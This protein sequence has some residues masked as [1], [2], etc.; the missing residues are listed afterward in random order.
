MRPS[1]GH[2]D[3]RKAESQQRRRPKSHKLSYKNRW[4]ISRDIVAHLR[5]A[6]VVCNII[7]P[8]RI[9]LAQYG[10]MS[11]GERAALMLLG[12]GVS[13]DDPKLEEVPEVIAAMREIKRVH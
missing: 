7:V 12:S 5:R 2:S 3:V 9:A 13:A 4:L 10:A 6:G 1:K 11:P 8:K